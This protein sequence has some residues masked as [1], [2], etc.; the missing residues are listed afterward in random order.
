MGKYSVVVL[1]W[2][3]FFVLLS[4]WRGFQ[5]RI[6]VSYKSCLIVFLLFFSL[7]RL[8]FCQLDN[9]CVLYYGF[10]IKILEWRNECEVE[11]WLVFWL[12]KKNEVRKKDC[13]NE[14]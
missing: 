12:C 7:V 4:E 2:N 6:V 8:Y 14:G 13:K 5:I 10:E 1:G 11:W 9:M 3:V